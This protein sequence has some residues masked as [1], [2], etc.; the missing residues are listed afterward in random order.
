MFS[1]GPYLLRSQVLL[2]PMAGISDQPFRRACLG[3]GAGL[4]VGEMLTAD[5]GLWQ[6]NKSRSRLAWG[7]QAAPISV[8]I[9]GAEPSQMAIAA[10]TAVA[11][12][13]QII[14]INMGCPAKKVCNRAAGSA[15]L[16]DESLVTAILQAV[17]KAVDVPVT[18]KIRTGWC[19]ASINAQRIAQIAEDSGIQALT[20]HGRTRACRFNGQAEYLTISD[21][22]QRVRIPVIANGDITDATQAREVLLQTG[23]AGVMIGR[24]AQG[25]PWI[26][27]E[28]NH[29]LRTGEQRPKPTPAEVGAQMA[30]HLQGIYELY[31]E[32]MGLRIARKH[33]AWYLAAHL[34]ASLAQAKRSEFNQITTTQEQLQLTQSLFGRTEPLEDQAA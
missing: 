18:L 3:Q 10:S 8:Q 33:F 25:N 24:A 1:I 5:I 23:A 32:H 26:F 6:S 11:L 7:T 34:P 4:V 29:L 28:I 14:D 22:V 12:G 21:V 9:A 19:P 13:A 20:I 2:A 27:S 15:L 17:V 16:R 30:E 31:G